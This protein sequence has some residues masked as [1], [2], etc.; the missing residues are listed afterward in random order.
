MGWMELFE[1]IAAC[2]RCPLSAGR[3]WTVP[4]EGDPDARLMLVGEGP[5]AEEDRLGRPFVGASGQL[6]TALL[7]EIGLS[8]RQVYIAN[9]VKCRPPGNRTP[10]PDEAEQCMPYLRAQFALVKPRALVLLGGTAAKYV[11]GEDVRIRRDHG[12]WS[13]RRGLWMMPTYHPSAMLRDVRQKREAYRD[14][15]SIAQKLRELE[16]AKV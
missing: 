3:T 10:A 8:R 11:L 14:F 16:D 9:I 4:G 2:A 1:E 6:L 5:G 12:R 7:E 13:E 15:Q